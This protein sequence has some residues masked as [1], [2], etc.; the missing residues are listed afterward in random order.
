MS[1]VIMMALATP[2]F[3]ISFGEQT[4]LRYGTSKYGLV[5]QVPSSDQVSEW[6]L[7]HDR[8]NTLSLRM[9]N[10]YEEPTKDHNLKNSSRKEEAGSRRRLDAEDRNKIKQELQKYTNPICS[11]PD[12]WLSNHK[13]KKSTRGS[14]CRQ[15]S[16]HLPS[17]GI[18]IH[19]KLAW[20]LSHNKKRGRDDGKIEEKAENWKC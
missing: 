9:D 13:W 12:K 6:I 11:E 7:A 18:Q 4:Y 16:F 20:R 1:V 5:G 17:Y 3:W 15:C 14:K 2:Y 8:C 19:G 10:A